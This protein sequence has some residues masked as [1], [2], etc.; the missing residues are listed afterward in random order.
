MLW[1]RHLGGL[2]EFSE[3]ELAIAD[4]SSHHQP[5]VTSPTAQNTKY[6][7]QLAGPS[8]TNLLNSNANVPHQQP[9]NNAQTPPTPTTNPL[10]LLLQRVRL[11]DSS[12][13]EGWKRLISNSHILPH[14]T[15]PVLDPEANHHLIENEPMLIAFGSIADYLTKGLLAIARRARRASLQA[16]SGGSTVVGGPA[17]QG[18]QQQQPTSVDVQDVYAREVQQ[19]S[20]RVAEK[21]YSDLG[22]TRF[23]GF[24]T[25]KVSTA[26]ANSGV[27]SVLPGGDSLANTTTPSVMSGGAAD[28][29]GR[30]SS[31]AG[32]DD[33]D[34]TDTNEPLITRYKVD[35][36]ALQTYQDEAIDWVSAN[37]A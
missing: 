4:A 33:D 20:Y 7:I 22:K 35:E 36:E 23:E 25:A 16:G 26:V 30:R 11:I 10:A 32:D 12:T 28:E 1:T 6:S 31:A 21:L 29:L 27:P 8:T 13:A 24:I 3:A 37:C 18:Q 2:V 34:D 14:V 9:T 17:A 5:P 19:R 15:E